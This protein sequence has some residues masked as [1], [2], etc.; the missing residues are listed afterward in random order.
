VPLPTPEG[1]EITTGRRSLG[2]V[3]CGVVSMY[4]EKAERGLGLEG[5]WGKGGEIEAIP[6]AIVYAR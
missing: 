3:R 5:R 1:P 6:G 2:T 4:G